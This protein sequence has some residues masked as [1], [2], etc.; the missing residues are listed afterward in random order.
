MNLL[1]RI[2]LLTP[3]KALDEL[4]NVS[5]VE[6]FI[7]I[8]DVSRDNLL[9][10]HIGFWIVGHVS[11]NVNCLLR[12]FVSR[13]LDIIGSIVSMFHKAKSNAIRSHDVSFMQV[14]YCKDYC[15]YFYRLW[16]ENIG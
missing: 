15:F 2:S 1:I 10:K 5:N 14:F 8:N 13:T 4:N 16:S 6:F 3:L 7:C 9:L 11:R 12:F